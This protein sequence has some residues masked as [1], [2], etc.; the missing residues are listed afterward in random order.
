MTNHGLSPGLGTCFSRI[1]FCYSTEMTDII[2]YFS[3]C[4]ERIKHFWD[5]NLASNPEPDGMKTN[6]FK[7]Q[8]DAMLH[9]QSNKP[10]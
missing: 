6:S 4:L 3:F 7:K 10:G 9:G 8:T 1:I 5:Y 2:A